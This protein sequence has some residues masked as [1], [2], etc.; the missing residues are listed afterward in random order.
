MRRK[1]ERKAAALY[2]FFVFVVFVCPWNALG[3]ALIWI[4]SVDII[5]LQP[6]ETDVITFDISGLAYQRPSWVDHN[7]FSQD[8]SSL[9]LDLYINKGDAYSFSE[10]TYSKLIPSLLADDYIL[11]INAIDYDGNVLR[12]TYLFEFTV[13]PE[14][15]SIAFLFCGLCFLSKVSKRHN[16]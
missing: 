4:E 16:K 15:T 1:N 13:V 2:V 6:A 7:E 5:P 3:D 10:W 8:G 11:E 14:P 9:Q 12:D